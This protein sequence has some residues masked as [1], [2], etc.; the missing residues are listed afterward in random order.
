MLVGISMARGCRPEGFIALM[1][2]RKPRERRAAS[3]RV[4]CRPFGLAPGSALGSVP[5]VVLS[6]A[7]VMTHDTT[8]RP[9]QATANVESASGVRASLVISGWLAGLWCAG[10]FGSGRLARSAAPNAEPKAGTPEW[11]VGRYGF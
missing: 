4:S 8:S 9:S 6:S 7:Q 2:S 5:T 1:P 10:G 11:E 3:P